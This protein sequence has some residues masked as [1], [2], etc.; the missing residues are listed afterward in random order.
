MKPNQLERDVWYQDRVGKTWRALDF[1]V[2]SRVLYEDGCGN[3]GQMD[4]KKFASKCVIK[5]DPRSS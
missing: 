2:G 3:V 4:I 1:L 5:A